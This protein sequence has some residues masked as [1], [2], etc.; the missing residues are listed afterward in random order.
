MGTC[1]PLFRTIFSSKSEPERKGRPT[2]AVLAGQRVFMWSGLLSDR[3]PF[4]PGSPQPARCRDTTSCVG[5]GRL[6]TGVRVVKKHRCH[7]RRSEFTNEYIGLSHFVLR[8]GRVNRAVFDRCRNRAG[9]K[10]LCPRPAHRVRT[11]RPQVAR[12]GRPKVAAK[13]PF[14]SLLIRF[15]GS[16]NRAMWSRGVSR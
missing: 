13:N 14:S 6:G 10:I 16:A 4:L 7:N 9:H 2:P 12:K 5:V 3:P 11:S 8:N 1:S 15:P